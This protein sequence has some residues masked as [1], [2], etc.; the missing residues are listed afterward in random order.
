M[1]RNESRQFADKVDK[2]KDDIIWFSDDSKY[3]VFA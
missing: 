1:I 2:L 3:L